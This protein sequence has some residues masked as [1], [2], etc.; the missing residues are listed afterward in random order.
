MPAPEGLTVTV[1]GSSA[2]IH[3]ALHALLFV[4]PTVVCKGPRRESMIENSVASC[5]PSEL[6]VSILAHLD[7]PKDLARAL[8]TC[9]SFLCISSDVWRAACYSRWPRWSSLATAPTTEWRRQYD[10]LLL[11]DSEGSLVIPS[12]RWTRNQL[13]LQPRHRRILVQWLC[14]VRCIPITLLLPSEALTRLTPTMQFTAWISG[15]TRVE[16]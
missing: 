14:E 12:E 1:T 8:C 4:L 10:L 13:L 3:L 5:V 9:K 11:R 15:G 16:P 2:R 6:W 7:D